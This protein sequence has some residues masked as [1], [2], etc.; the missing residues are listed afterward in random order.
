MK[1]LF[2]WLSRRRFPYEPLITVELSKGN[3]IHNLN[4]FKKIAPLGTVAPVLKSNAYGHGLIEVA[5]VLKNETI[6]FFIVDSYF[7]AISLRAK[8][9]KVPLLVIGYTRPQTIAQSRL[10]DTMFVITALDTL[11]KLAGKKPSYPE[12][13]DDGNYA[14]G[15]QIPT[16]KIVR[17]Q[18]KIDTGMRRQGLLPQEVDRAID[19]IKTNPHLVLKGVCTHFSDADDTDTS[20]T[21][22]QIDLWNKTMK[23]IRAAFPSLRYVH[24]SATDG[25]QFTQE[26]D[27]NMS[28][29]GI[30][31]YG[32]SENQNLLKKVNLKPVMKIKTIITG[33]KPLKRGE[34]VGYGNVFAAERDMTIATIPF[35]YFEGLDRRLS[36]KGSVQVGSKKIDCR[37]VGR[38][39]MNISTID[40]SGTHGVKIGDEVTVISGDQTDSNSIT[41][42]AQ[43][44]GTISYEVAVK[45][46]R[47]LKREVVN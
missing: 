40:V 29:L 21:D 25:H 37:I 33:V 28:R 14:E 44:I 39:S 1:R 2:R 19:L 47:Q 18:L 4:E 7:E 9:I 36:S 38:V 11:E 16:T 23:K 17:I 24:A 15:C 42:I 3:L 30:G 5:S 31:L 43:T 20:F 13:E 12:G 41:H 35:G 8:G 26:I 10:R 32:L 27:A 46:D 6:P 34:T 45:I 22:G